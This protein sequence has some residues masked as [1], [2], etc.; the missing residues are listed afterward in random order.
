[1]IE[2]VTVIVVIGVLAAAAAPAFRTLSASREAAAAGELR[3]QLQVA[4]STAIATGKPTGLTCTTS[5]TITPVQ[6]ESPGTNPV[7][8][9]NP[10]G[11]RHA[12]VSIPGLYT[13]VTITAIRS[14]SGESG[15]MT[16][17]FGFDGT[18][19]SRTSGGAAASA[20]A[21]DGQITL[22]G[23]TVVSIRRVTGVI[24]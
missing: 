14:G 4:R 18:P 24:E 10:L 19:Q 22:S 12:E 1:M 9:R 13:G 21:S 16:I 3:R 17:W 2:L 8:L 23:G 7:A 20:W 5:S 6:I 15:S 11:E